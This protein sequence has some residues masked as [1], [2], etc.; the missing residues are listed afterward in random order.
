M[1]RNLLLM[2][3][4]I[5]LILAATFLLDKGLQPPAPS[6]DDHP[7]VT[8]LKTR[9]A[10]DFPFTVW[11]LDSV[12][13]L[14]NLRGKVVLLNFW[15]SWCAPCVIE[16][17]KLTELAQAYP[18]TLVVLAVSADSDAKDIERFLKKAKHTPL[19]NLLIVHDGEKKISQDLFQTIKLPETIII[20]PAGQ[21]VR[22]VVG[23]TDWTG[24]GMRAYLSSLVPAQ[25]I[26]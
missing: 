14:E 18:D 12:S 22:K 7:E 16:F 19:K 20:D 15:A 25:P 21:M 8:T 23:D 10:P 11:G 4:A 5:A 1:R 13:R 24:P 9:P 17:P 26:P 2:S 3:L 6:F